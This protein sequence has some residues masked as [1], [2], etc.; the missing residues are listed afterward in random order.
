M[1]GNPKGGAVVK[2]IISHTTKKIQ[3]HYNNYCLAINNSVKVCLASPRNARIF[4]VFRPTNRRDR[5]LRNPN[6]HE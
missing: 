1:L 3:W 2:T 4:I 5:P 6:S